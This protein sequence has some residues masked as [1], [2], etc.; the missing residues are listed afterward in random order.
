MHSKNDVFSPILAM[1][2][3]YHPPGFQEKRLGACDCWLS[4]RC[5]AVGLFVLI[6]C[7]FE[8]CVYAHEFCYAMLMHRCIN[9]HVYIY[10]LY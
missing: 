2:N 3:G 9:M 6:F 8:E 1:Y 7:R 10:I 4:C 5:F